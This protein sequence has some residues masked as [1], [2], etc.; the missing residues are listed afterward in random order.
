MWATLKKD[1]GGKE[2]V[3]QGFSK[4]GMM[5]VPTKLAILAA[6]S[7]VCASIDVTGNIEAEDDAIRLSR[8][9]D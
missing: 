8:G 6:A 4:N 3:S 2:V 1:A 5:I 9:Q 7:K